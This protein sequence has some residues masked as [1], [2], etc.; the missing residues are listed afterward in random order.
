MGRMKRKQVRKPK[1]VEVEKPEY[2]ESEYAAVSIDIL[3]KSFKKTDRKLISLLK[4]Y[5]QRRWI[6]VREDFYNENVS[7]DIECKVN[8][9]NE[10]LDKIKEFV[11]DVLEN[12]ILKHR[13]QVKKI[14]IKIEDINKDPHNYYGK[15][16]S[17]FIGICMKR[18]LELSNEEVK[19]KRKEFED[20]IREI[21]A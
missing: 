10:P 12:S 2:A 8:N 3:P 11:L 6:K 21:G 19:E 15:Y 4:K 13:N 17:P 18:Y 5:F 7:L 16:T 20:K 9:I 14:K 1:A